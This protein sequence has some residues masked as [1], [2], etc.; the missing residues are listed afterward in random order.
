MYTHGNG[1]FGKCRETAD[2]KCE[3]YISKSQVNI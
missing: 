3:K 1:I 2:V